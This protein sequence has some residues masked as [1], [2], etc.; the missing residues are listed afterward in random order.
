MGAALFV[1]AVGGHRD[2][3]ETVEKRKKKRMT[4]MTNLSSWIRCDMTIYILRG[5]DHS[6]DNEKRNLCSSFYTTQA[7]A[8]N[9][10]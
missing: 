5:A 3:F 7:T 2:R 8:L 9:Y 10:I 1:L 6:Q 4:E